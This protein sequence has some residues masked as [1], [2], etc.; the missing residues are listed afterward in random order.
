MSGKLSSNPDDVIIT[1]G[2]NHALTEMSSYSSI[3]IYDAKYLWGVYTVGDTKL[4]NTVLNYIDINNYN[5]SISKKVLPYIYVYEIRRNCKNI[6]NCIE[7]PN[8][9]SSDKPTFIP[10]N[11]TIVITERMYNNPITHV[12]PSLDDVI[13]PFTIHLNSKDI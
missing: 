4:N 13:L 5:D 12:G 6:T 8:I 7:V 2:I 10:F 3:S 11:D 9:P 1:V